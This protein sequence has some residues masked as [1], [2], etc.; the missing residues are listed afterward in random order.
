MVPVM[1]WK[2][3]MLD[4][5]Q[6][7]WKSRPGPSQPHCNHLRLRP[8]SAIFLRR[9]N[10]PSTRPSPAAIG[11]LVTVDVHGDSHGFHGP[12]RGVQFRLHHLLAIDFQEDSVCDFMARL[13]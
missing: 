10:S 7:S 3:I 13:H 12:W 6:S 5:A 2:Y 11:E 8:R 9:R 1:Y 4:M